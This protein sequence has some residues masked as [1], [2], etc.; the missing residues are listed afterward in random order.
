M[1]IVVTIPKDRYKVDDAENKWL[2]QSPMARAFWVMSKNPTKLKVGDRVW[3]VRNN[4][5]HSSMKVRQCGVT[6]SNESNV[7]STSGKEWKG[8]FK[9]FMD[10]FR[11]EKEIEYNGFMG[12]RYYNNNK[13]ENLWKRK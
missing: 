13:K 5:I 6:K 7:C 3:F 11:Y 9:I 4:K 2:E 12:F 8:I 1:D 10:D